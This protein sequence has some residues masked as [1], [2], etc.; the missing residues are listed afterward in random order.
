MSETQ[1]E[2]WQRIIDERHR[3]LQRRAIAERDLL[4][5]ISMLGAALQGSV[6]QAAKTARAFGV[7]ALAEFK[8]RRR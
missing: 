1:L 4:V 5:A 2:A 8:A 3:H 7:F 6:L